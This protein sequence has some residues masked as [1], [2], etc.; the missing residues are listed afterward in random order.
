[1]LD[2]C[3]A[4][5]AGTAGDFH[6]ACGLDQHFLRFVGVDSAALK[7]E[8]AKGLGDSDLLNWIQANASFKRE[9]WEIAQ[10]SAFQEAA[11]PMS[12]EGRSGFNDMLN[13]LNAGHRT[14]ILTSFDRL[15]LDDFVSYG[16]KA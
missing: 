5:I 2:K 12:N 4:E 14:D 1:M 13:G 9:P 15:D 7:E 8:V 11:A 10:W 3:R 6:Y 16:G